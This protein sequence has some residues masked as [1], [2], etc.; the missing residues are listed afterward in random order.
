MTLNGKERRVSFLGDG[1]RMWHD[2]KMIGNEG[3]GCGMKGWRPA[4]GF[5]EAYQK[6]NLNSL[7]RF[8]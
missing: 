2:G 4:L 1:G 3:G 5:V 8:P 7:S 6:N